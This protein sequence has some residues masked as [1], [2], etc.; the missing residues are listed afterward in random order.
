[1]K[2]K[3]H[4]YWS[5]VVS[6]LCWSPSQPTPYCPS[7]L[8]TA[9]YTNILM[10]TQLTTYWARTMLSPLWPVRTRLGTYWRCKCFYVHMNS[11]LDGSYSSRT[12]SKHTDGTQEPVVTFRCDVVVLYHTVVVRVYFL[13]LL[14]HWPCALVFQHSAATAG[15]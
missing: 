3:K 12:N 13:P 10:I 5:I 15:N 14:I 1:M 11:T 2:I 6:S 7:S 4:W 8:T 9:D